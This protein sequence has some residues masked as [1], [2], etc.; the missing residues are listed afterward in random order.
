MTPEPTPLEPIPL[1]PM[2][3]AEERPPVPDREERAARIR[4]ALQS[5]GETLS[6]IV[7]SVEEK[8]GERCPYRNAQDECTFRGGCRNKVRRPGEAPQCGGD[9]LIRWES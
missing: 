2:P 9:Q 1:E 8:K 6:D 5:L 7:S 3:P 4:R